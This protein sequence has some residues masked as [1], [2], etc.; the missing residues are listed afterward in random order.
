MQYYELKDENLR[1]KAFWSRDIANKIIDAAIIKKN[2]ITLLGLHRINIIT[3]STPSARLRMV[4]N[5]VL[6]RRPHEIRPDY[7]FDRRF[8]TQSP[9][10][11]VPRAVTVPA[12]REM[13]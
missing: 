4:Q 11:Q 7:P 5:H 6:L 8:A 9:T 1:D 13:R 12:V 3:M 2:P 10:L